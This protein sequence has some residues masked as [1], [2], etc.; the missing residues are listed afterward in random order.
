MRL[1]SKAAAL[2]NLASG[3]IRDLNKLARDSQCGRFNEFLLMSTGRFARLFVDTRHWSGLEMPAWLRRCLLA[4]LTRR[5]IKFFKKEARASK[6]KFHYGDITIPTF[7]ISSSNMLFRSSQ[8]TF[9]GW[10]PQ[11]PIHGYFRLFYWLRF[12]LDWIPREY[13]KRK[14][15]LIAPTYEYHFRPRL[16]HISANEPFMSHDWP[17]ALHLLMPRMRLCCRHGDAADARRR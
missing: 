5:G 15:S 12:H 11:N 10:F 7:I 16:A 4:S 2:R 9:F 1:D 8:W 17:W 3:Q 6:G 14:Y 13:V